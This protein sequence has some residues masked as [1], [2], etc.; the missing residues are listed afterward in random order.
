MCSRAHVCVQSGPGE[1][2]L[3]HMKHFKILRENDE[4][5]PT[6]NATPSAILPSIL[7]QLLGLGRL[8]ARTPP[9]QISHKLKMTLHTHAHRVRNFPHAFPPRVRACSHTILSMFTHAKRCVRS[10]G[11]WKLCRRGERWTR[12]RIPLK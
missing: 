2:H 9:E 4:K 11:L 8:S 6:K 3:Q 1:R 10:Q 7:V 5:K 12:G